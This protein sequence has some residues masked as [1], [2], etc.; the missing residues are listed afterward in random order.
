M[1]RPLGFRY[2]RELPGRRRSECWGGKFRCAAR[3][4]RRSFE[5]LEQSLGSRF[6]VEWLATPVCEKSNARDRC[7]GKETPVCAQVAVRL[8]EC[9]HLY[10]RRPDRYLQM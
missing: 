1:I 4:Q 3:I 6:T 5:K 8:G 7:A 2:R 9:E 10:R